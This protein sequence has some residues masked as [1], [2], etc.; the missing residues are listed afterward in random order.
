VGF[1]SLLEVH[2]ALD[3]LFAEHQE[4]LLDRDTTTATQKLAAFDAGIREHI[5]L[6]DRLFPI[7]RRAGRIPGG[8]VEL[9]QAEHRKILDYVVRF[10][11][12]IEE[13]AGCIPDSQAIIRLMDEEARFKSLM[14]HHDLRG[15]NILYAVLDRVATPG[16]KLALLSR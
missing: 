5:A 14:E 1:G 9:Y 10:R 11:A 3:A 13:M 7:Y 12:A 8:A 6:E 15:R 4:A 2:R 16:E